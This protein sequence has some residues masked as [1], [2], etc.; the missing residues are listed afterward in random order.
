MSAERAI[1]DDFTTDPWWWEAA[2]PWPSE[3][4]PLPGTADVLVVGA[5]YTGLSA[6]LT[7]AQAGRDV[8]VLDRLMPGE[9]AS[10]RN[11]G[12]V[13][14]SLLGGFSRMAEKLGLPETVTL[15]RGAEDAY[16]YVVDLMGR[17]AID[18]HLVHRGRLLPVWNQA[19]YDE[20]AADFALQQQHLGIE[21][22][23]LSE[24][25]LSQ[26]LRVA[27]AR[28]ALLIENTSSVH[29]GMYHAGLRR[30]VEAAGARV[31]G[32]CAVTKLTREAGGFAVRTER[33]ALRAREVV[34]ATNAYTGGLT[35]WFRRRLVRSLATMAAC[36]PKDPALLKSL[37]PADRTYSDYSRYQFNFWRIAPDAPSRLL[38]GG[39]TGLMFKRPEEIA[40][41]LQADL[42]RIFPQ[43]EG[44]RF[45]H[46]WRGEVAFTMDRLPHLGVREG[47][48]FALGCNA[49]GLPMGTWIGHKVALELLG[50]PESAT[51]YDERRFP[52]SPSILGYPWFMPILTTWARWQ[53]WRGAAS[54]GH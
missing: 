1:T 9:A 40:H 49:A 37:M 50:D 34:I 4:A 25:E 32:G 47:V 39:Q 46:L 14:R 13:G 21:G 30:A 17:L 16:D 29:P 44:T 12:F 33:G 5:G 2:R 26:E 15:H 43:L 27:G 8:L 28:G 11:A 38:F 51:P 7:L 23:M 10:S 19:Q 3:D 24:Q 42:G 48:H 36:E 18:C 54:K 53:D 35:P 45:S 31:T 20:T 22:G 6:A 52:I 41:R